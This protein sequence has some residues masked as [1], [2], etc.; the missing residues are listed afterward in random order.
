LRHRVVPGIRKVLFTSSLE[1]LHLIRREA[2][3]SE[4]QVFATVA[5]HDVSIGQHPPDHVLCNL[6]VVLNLAS[7]LIE[8]RT[9]DVRDGRPPVSAQKFAE[10][11][12]LVD[13]RH[14]HV[15][16]H[17]LKQFVEMHDK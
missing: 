1:P 17:E 3:V 14:P 6:G 9:S 16:L 8:Q 13:V 7:I 11:Y 12:R 5:L 4:Q 10:H 15:A 2:L